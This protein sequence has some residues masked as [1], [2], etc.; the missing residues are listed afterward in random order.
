MLQTSIRRILIAAGTISLAAGCSA[1]SFTSGQPSSV[2]PSLQRIPHGM[3]VLPGPVVAGPRVVSAVPKKPNA[4]AGWPAPK[5]KE[6][7]FVADSSSGVLIYNPKAANSS[8]IGSITTGVNAPAGVAVDK[9][10]NVYVTNEGSNTVT[11]YGPGS[12]SP[13][14]TISSGIS[15]PYGI[16][17]DSKGNVFVSNLGTNDVTAYAAGQTSPYE[18]ISFATEGQ[19]V[20]IGVDAGDNVWVACDS[21]NGVFEIPAGSSG[22]INSGLTSLAGPISVAFGKKDV[23]YVSNFS[24]SDVNVYS[25]GSTSPS[26]QITTGIERYGPTL[27]GFTAKSAYF[28]ANQDDNVV[29]YKR[30]K[31]SPFSTLSGASFPLGIASSPLVKK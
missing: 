29:G 9:A 26:T 18:T 25:Y 11:V 10:G 14:L 13:S 4:P 27:G 20:G 30:K 5:G 21:S 22:V 3:R 12:G 19:A 8:P 24:G 7:L 1:N 17:V 15:S 28:Q 31:T 6:L 16:G 2:A 23:I